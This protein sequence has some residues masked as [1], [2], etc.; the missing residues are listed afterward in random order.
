[1]N[2]ERILAALRAGPPDEP[3]YVP[4][5]RR[6]FGRAGVVQARTRSRIGSTR[7]L[8]L[9]AA[10]AVAVVAGLIAAGGRLYRSATPPLT[11][12]S[13]TT[14]RA[15][16]A[17]PG[18][19]DR[20]LAEGTVRIG[21]PISYTHLDGQ[22]RGAFDRGVAEEIARRL[23]VRLE[24]IRT[25]DTEIARGGWYGHFDFAI[26]STVVGPSSRASLGL[27]VPYYYQ[28]AHVVI[29]DRS[30]TSLRGL[31][32]HEACVGFRSYGND[33]LRGRLSLDSASAIVEPPS[34]VTIGEHASQRPCLSEHG[35]HWTFSVPDVPVPL[36]G[37]AIR[38][39]EQPVFT[40]QL[41]FALVSGADPELMA[42][43]DSLIDEMRADGTL[44][45]LTTVWLGA[46]VSEPPR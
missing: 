7:I 5:H 17:P 31:T 18:S 35:R 41:A 39:L 10:V 25:D 33:W 32:G 9:A 30:I 19:L 12:P 24:R 16:S 13:P 1:M 44:G 4:A 14:N 42:R 40:E 21:Y 37:P 15:I 6:V 8:L 27:T 29:Y 45:R 11:I 38:L 20:I 36:P 34:N 46:D 23:G 22:G 28:P 43:L 2:E 26:A 3:T